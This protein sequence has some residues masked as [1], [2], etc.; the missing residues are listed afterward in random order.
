MPL[1]KPKWLR[2]EVLEKGIPAYLVVGV[3]AVAAL[4]VWLPLR[5]SFGFRFAI[6]RAYE[7]ARHDVLRGIIDRMAT[8]HQRAA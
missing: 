2:W 6:Q 5:E 1:K 8:I 3:G 4:A 7:E